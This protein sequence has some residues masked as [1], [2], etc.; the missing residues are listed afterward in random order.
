MPNSIKPN[1]LVTGTP[2]AGKSYICAHLADELQLNWLDCSKIAKEKNFVEEYD[3]EYDCPILDEDKLLD[4]ME[5]II[6]QGGNIVEYHGCDFFPQ[7]WFDAVFVVVCGNSVLYDR[8]KERGYNEKKLK[9]NIECEIF[10]TI[11]E[12]AR[13]SYDVEI[14]FQLLSDTVESGKDS[15]E[16]VKKWFEGNKSKK[17]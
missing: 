17:T 12:E 16:V 7:R 6:Q 8:L 14:V 1:I 13:E 11:L 3:K 9:S 2:G 10:G 4:Y 5:P 15:V